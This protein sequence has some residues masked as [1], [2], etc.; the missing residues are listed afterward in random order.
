M[1]LRCIK[2]SGLLT[3]S[4]LSLPAQADGMLATAIDA[5]WQRAVIASEVAGERRAAEADVDSAARWLA[6][7]PSIALS[8]EDD[9][10][11]DDRGKRESGIDL[12][13]PL[14]LPGQRTAHGQAAAASLAQADTAQR[15]ARWRV[16]GEVRENAWRVVS[17]QAEVAQ[18][19]AASDNLA[20]LTADVSRRV[21]AGDLPRTDLLAAQAEELAAR[22]RLGSALLMLREAELQWRTLTGFERMPLAA[23]LSETL[24]TDAA[25]DSDHPALQ[26]AAREAESTLRQLDLARTARSAPPE[27]TLGWRRDTGGHGVPGEDSVVVGIRLPFGTDARNKPLLAR[28][29]AA[30]A[31]AS[32]RETRQR[33]YVAAAIAV[34]RDALHLAEA[35][36]VAASEQAQ[37]LRD[38]SELLQ[39]AFNAGELALPELLRALAMAGEADANAARQQAMLGLARARLMQSLGQYP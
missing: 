37:L 36:A 8:H 35:Q 3:A 24:P 26:E 30:T 10:W 17:L 32:T 21:A 23:E 7:P 34:A 9:H 2:W 22:N 11:H 13:L 19:T 20:Q 39:R 18:M 33:E 5:A 6:E 12:N 29:E 4:L 28:A 15:A 31:T 16:A 27:L 38:R 25:M 14:W 1:N